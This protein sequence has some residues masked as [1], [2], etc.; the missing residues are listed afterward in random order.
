[1]SVEVSGHIGVI[2]SAWLQGKDKTQSCKSNDKKTSEKFN[3]ETKCSYNCF[4]DHEN[5]SEI[6]K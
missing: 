2:S 5:V 1:M 4:S 3:K 6:E